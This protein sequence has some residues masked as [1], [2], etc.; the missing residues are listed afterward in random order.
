VDRKLTDCF[1]ICFFYSECYL[2]P[3]F[4]T[5]ASVL[6]AGFSSVFRQEGYKGI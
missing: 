2:F 6:E 4:C 1:L 3:Q 5:N